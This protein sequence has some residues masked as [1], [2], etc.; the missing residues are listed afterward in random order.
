MCIVCIVCVCDLIK[1]SP[2][3]LILASP[4]CV[5]CVCARVVCVRIM[6]VRDLIRE[7]P[8]ELLL[9]SHA[10]CACG[11]GGVEVELIFTDMTTSCAYL[12]PIPTFNPKPP[13]PTLNP[14][15]PT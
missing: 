13:I 12:N 10:Y 7:S 6:C 3:D 14:K 15:P 8:P 11:R 1:E 9:L 4:V 2:P 5:R